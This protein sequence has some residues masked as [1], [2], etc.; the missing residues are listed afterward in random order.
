HESGSW[1]APG[2]AS[3]SG[4]GGTAGG[5]LDHLWGARLGDL[6]AGLP[7]T[8]MTSR[9]AGLRIALAAILVQAP[10][11]VLVVLG[12]D[13]MPVPAP[14]E[15]ALLVVAG[16]GTALV[17]TGGNLYLAHTVAQV[18]SWRRTLAAAWVLVLAASG[19]LVLPLIVAGI[20][21]RSVPQ[22]LGAGRLEWTWALL[23][24]LAHELTAAGCVLASAAWAAQ[25]AAAGAGAAGP[26][27]TAAAALP[28]GGEARLPAAAAGAA[29]LPQPAVDRIACRAGC[30]RSFVSQQAEIAH[31]RHCPRR[32]PGAGTGPAN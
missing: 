4:G 1:P 29:A 5:E 19:G 16:I 2:A 3:V 27:L 30:G 8:P 24:A 7:E 15:R 21:A 14:A 22:V 20:S 17:L 6:D 26:L 23:A 28:A 18:R 32:R 31:L 11:L 12:A 13:R 10:R 25:A 9:S